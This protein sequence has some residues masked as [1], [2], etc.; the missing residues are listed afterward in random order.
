[1]TV[2]AT[3]ETIIDGKLKV[4]IGRRRRRAP[5]YKGYGALKGDE[6]VAKFSGTVNLSANQLTYTC[7]GTLYG[8]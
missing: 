2:R 3:S 4:K 8:S 6:L 7:K 5:R 1:V